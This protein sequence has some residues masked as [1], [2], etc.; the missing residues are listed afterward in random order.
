MSARA[1]DI[2]RVL[3]L[4]VAVKTI[5]QKLMDLGACHEAVEWVA[6]C[7]G[8]TLMEMWA[9]CPR[10]DWMW[11]LLIKTPK[12]MP[13]KR[14]SVAF[15]KWCADS[16]KKHSNTYA[17]AA[18]HATSA[19]ALAAYAAAYAGAHAAHA[20]HAASADADAAADSAFAAYAASSASAA[21]AYAAAYAGAAAE[22]LDQ[23]DYIREHFACPVLP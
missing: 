18:A 9:R 17:Y 4:G 10:G 6:E 11:W 22:R 16:A 15:A 1:G 23:S 8:N 3:R 20:A 5:A 13:P 2:A 12:T 19:A 21:A 14:Q 7:K